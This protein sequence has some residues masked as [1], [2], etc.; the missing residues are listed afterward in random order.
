MAAA[1]AP[2]TAT[3]EPRRIGLIA[4]GG[5]F[6]FAVA[7][8]ARLHGYH[9]VCAGIRYEVEPELAAQVDDFKV[10]G[11]G[12][13][14]A[15]LRYFRR[16]GVRD[17][18]WAGWVRKDRLFSAGRLLSVLPDWRMIKLW[19]FKLRDRQSQ[20]LLAAIADEFEA[21]GMNVSHSARFCP[22]MLVEEGVL[23]RRRPTPNQLA[24]IRFGWKVAKRMADLDVGQSV[25]V[26][27][28]STL[29]VEGLEGTDRN[30][31][32]AGELCRKRGF[33]VVKLA[34]EGHDMRFDIPTV[35]PATVEAMR[36][37]GAAVLAL[38]AGKTLLL[39]RE[40]TLRTADR[41][42]IVVIALRGPPEPETS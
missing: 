5:R 8:S 15:T 24:D 11:L 37:A 7:R 20:T 38:E 21:E 3:V 27:E 34:K 14:G 1:E 31:L 32:R 36:Q 41:C 28:K 30:I 33:T 25:A 17:V 29:A 35:G 16:H 12:R 23:G 40:E 4:G 13:L 26:F 39:D 10:F 9:V 22:E 18:S 2:D 19:C 42:G 6:P